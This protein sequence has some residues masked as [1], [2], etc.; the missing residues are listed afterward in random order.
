MKWKMLEGNKGKQSRWT[1]YEPVSQA[2]LLIVIYNISVFQNRADEMNLFIIWALLSTQNKKERTK[3]AQSL[4][5]G[6]LLN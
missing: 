2:L 1:G 6:K 3:A 4:Y 5:K